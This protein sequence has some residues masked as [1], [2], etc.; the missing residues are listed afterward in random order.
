MLPLSATAPNQL[1]SVNKALGRR[2]AAGDLRNAPVAR[3]QPS[4]YRLPGCCYVLSL[5]VEAE[6][7]WQL[8]GNTQNMSCLLVRGPSPGGAGLLRGAHL[9]L[10]GVVQKAATSSF[11]RV[12]YSYVA[13]IVHDLIGQHAAQEVPLVLVLS[14]HV[15]QLKQLVLNL[16]AGCR[17]HR[18]SCSKQVLQVRPAEY[19][20][21]SKTTAGSCCSCNCGQQNKKQQRL[22]LM[23]QRT[24]S[25]TLHFV[26]NLNLEFQLS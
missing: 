26:W 1:S 2:Q 5:L 6:R 3:L 14:A 4:T 11:R 12:P 16:P 13:V 10:L 15:E 8:A 9:C 7:S 20:K 21:A 17:Q 24:D 19:V 18:G 22:Q 25:C 23:P